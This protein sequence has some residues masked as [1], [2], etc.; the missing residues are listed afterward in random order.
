VTVLYFDCFSGASGDMILGALIDAGAPADEVEATIARLPIERVGFR[1]GRAMRGG[2]DATDIEIEIPDVATHRSYRDIVEIIQGAE[3]PDRVRRRALDTFEILA[4]AEGKI[5]GVTTDEVHFHE[6]GALDTIA[7]VVG[8]AVAIEHFAPETIVAST[9]PMGS[10]TVE[11]AHGTIPVPAPAVTEILA[12]VPLVPGG[13]GEVITPTGAAI[14][15][16]ACDRFGDP[17]PMVLRAS[18]YGAGSKDL[19]MPN[20]LRVM[21]GDAVEPESP[22]HLL[23]ETNI[24]DMSPELI[25]Y[26]IDVLIR[27][28]AVDAWSTPIVMKKGRPALKLSA[29]VE[30]S[31]KE[32]VLDVFYRET[33]TLGVRSLPIHKD[34]LLREWI[35]I[36]LEGHAIRIKIA[37][38]GTDVVTVAPEYED[39]AKA[40]RATGLPLKEVYARAALAARM[41]LKL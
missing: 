23:L 5:H 15:K 41:S 29:L 22:E 30:G 12:G 35:E 25:P 36:E 34:E 8:A 4:I 6:V 17:P 39:A 9:I 14:L 31:K 32:R 20:V 2:I 7:D 11:S 16:A 21:V 38:R 37:R 19:S 26:V 10:G 3:L 1:H 40:A 33:T 13:E 24:D 28:G 27:E 18:G